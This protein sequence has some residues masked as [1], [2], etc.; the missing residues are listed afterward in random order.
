MRASDMRTRLQQLGVDYNAKGATTKA[1]LRQLLT[2]ALVISP[3]YI[4]IHRFYFCLVPQWLSY[5]N[6]DCLLNK[7]YTQ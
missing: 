6:Q 4:R 1:E 2:K 7:L 5:T 3:D